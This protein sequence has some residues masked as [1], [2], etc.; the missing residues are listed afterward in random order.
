[1]ENKPHMNVF[2]DVHKK[3]QD[4][5][6]DLRI[7]SEERLGVRRKVAEKEAVEEGFDRPAAESVV[8]VS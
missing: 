5:K 1:M 8:E 6:N 2:Q 3:I 4:K 7:A